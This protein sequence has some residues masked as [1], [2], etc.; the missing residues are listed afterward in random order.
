M[1]IIEY[2]ELM[3][4]YV[5]GK[6][7]IEKKIEF[8]YF[9]NAHSECLKEVN[10]L[11]LVWESMDSNSNSPE[12]RPE[13]D[14]QFY[15]FLNSETPKETTKKPSIFEHVKSLF[16][17]IIFNPNTGRLA[18]GIV[19]LAIGVFIGN[20]LDFDA[21][22]GAQNTETQIAEIQ[23]VRSQ[24][25]LA[26][27]EQPSANKRLQAVNEVNELKEV[28]EIVINALFTTL[29]NDV[30]TNVRLATIESLSN[31]VY[32]PSVREGL[33]QS[34]IKQNSPLVQIALA[35][36]MVGIDEKRSITPFR[37]LLKKEEINSAAKQK[38]EQS[39][40]SLL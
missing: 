26:L 5:A 17:N 32:L 10:G 13:M 38:I 12:P 24:L 7:N 15:T 37:K 31:F 6:L 28:E 16:I 22:N 14:T 29:N 30:N 25:V 9:I 36:L 23:K 1:D 39:I 33:V 34:I 27:L 18:Y 3:M 19:I 8:E 4:D 21:F 11:K 40:Q 2:K 20:K 35:D